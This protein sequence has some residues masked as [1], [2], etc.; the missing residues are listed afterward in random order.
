MLETLPK[1]KVPPTSLAGTPSMRTLLAVE[2][3]PRTK[4][5]VTLPVWPV[6]TATLPGDWRRSSTMPT[7]VARSA[8]GMRVTAELT[9]WRGVGIPVAVTVTVRL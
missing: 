1:S 8:C 5:E 3:P 4:S 9:C 2:L 6:W 7:R